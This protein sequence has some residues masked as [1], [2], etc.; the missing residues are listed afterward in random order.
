MDQPF[1]GRQPFERDRAARVKAAGGNADFRAE[2]EFARLHANG[3]PNGDVH[4]ADLLAHPAARLVWINGARVVE[5]V[6]A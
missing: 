6:G 2:A 5:E 4:V 3:Q 1:I